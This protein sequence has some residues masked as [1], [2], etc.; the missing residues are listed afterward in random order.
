LTIEVKH[1]P[2]ATL[3]GEIRS[4]GSA[5][6]RK[7]G[8]LDLGHA[9]KMRK[10]PN[11][12]R[13]DS[14]VFQQPPHHPWLL[15]PELRMSEPSAQSHANEHQPT[16]QS[17][18]QRTGSRNPRPSQRRARSNHREVVRRTQR[19]RDGLSRHRFGAQIHAL[20]VITFPPRSG[21]LSLVTH[22]G[23]SIHGT[24]GTAQRV[25][26]TTARR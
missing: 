18:R 3:K 23:L 19:H 9:V 8:Q 25:H 2:I 1:L 12:A 17:R 6:S 21:C 5:S 26:A 22:L 4:D 10:N 16:P 14:R 11:R 24:I 15:R 20:E 7:D 13:F